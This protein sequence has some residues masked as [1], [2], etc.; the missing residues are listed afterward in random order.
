MK[1][2][3]DW[4]VLSVAEAKRRGLNFSGKKNNFIFFF[5]KTSQEKA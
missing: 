1:I 4:E 5:Q 2:D 3:G